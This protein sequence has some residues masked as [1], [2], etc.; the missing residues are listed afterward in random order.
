LPSC[1]DGIENC[2]DGGCEEGIDCGG[3][4]KP[5]PTVTSIV[6]TTTEIQATTIVT[7]TTETSTTTSMAEITTTT[8]P[9]K[10]EAFPLTIA[11]VIAEVVIIAGLIVFFVKVKGG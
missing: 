4:C 1:F 9:V 8:T 10:G 5:C 11:V 2:H 3:P 7:S 6:T